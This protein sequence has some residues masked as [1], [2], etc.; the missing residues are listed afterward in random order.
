MY[1]PM[2]GLSAWMMQAH[3]D[4]RYALLM[5]LMWAAMM[6]GMMLPSA[7]PAI[8]LFNRVMRGSAG[9]QAP[10]A[11]SYAF[12]AGYLLA[13]SAFSLVAT[14]LQ[15][16]LARNALL[17]PML[18]ARGALLIAALLILA[19]AWQFTALKQACLTRCRGPLEFIT[20]HFRPGVR[21]ALV[22][23]AH[24][25]LYCVGCCWA[26]MLLLF[27]GG[28]MNL[29]VIASIAVFV[30][31]EKLAP[32][33]PQTGRLGGAALVAAGVALLVVRFA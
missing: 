32:L 8:L 10:V 19:G 13:W 29:L 9:A 33:G 4:P 16:L 26:L 6:A 23:G 7:V 25:G 3:W 17:S 15:W 11:R 27:C 21:G 22:L 30:L 12:A 5:F 28:V 20:Q 14:A 24:H 31:L 18:E 2:T 1:G